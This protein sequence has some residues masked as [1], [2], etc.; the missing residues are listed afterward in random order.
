MPHPDTK[1]GAYHLIVRKQTLLVF[2]PTEGSCNFLDMMCS[3][4]G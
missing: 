2:D 4:S 1:T 3:F